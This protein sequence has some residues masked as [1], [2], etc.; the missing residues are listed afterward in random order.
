MLHILRRHPLPVSAHFRHSLVLTYALPPETLQPLL[1]PGLEL[2]T[3]ENCAFVAVAMVQTEN[4]RPEFMP[5]CVGQDFFLAGYRIFARYRNGTRNLR[6]LRILRSD[7]D[8]RLMV[9][10]GNLLTHYNYRK[11]DVTLCETPQR[12]E[13]CIRTPGAM[14]DLDVVMDR[15]CL[16]G[17]LPEGSPFRNEIEAFRFAGPLPYTFDYEPQTHSMIIIKGVRQNWHPQLA[18]VEVRE[19]TF[20]KQQP[21]A[22][23]NPVLASAFYVQDIPYRW[24]SG[25]RQPL[26]EVQP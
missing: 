13:I 19:N 18:N 21:F 3:F 15:M 2:D 25:R 20:L 4:L 16:P 26:Q 11:C 24:E 6:G 23:S 17:S 12:L 7:T 1:P 22:N 10:S 9:F 14:A 5:H 8:R